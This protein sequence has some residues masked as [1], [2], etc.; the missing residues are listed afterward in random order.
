MHAWLSCRS[1]SLIQIIHQHSYRI[2]I[3][4]IAASHAFPGVV[5]PLFRIDQCLFFGLASMFNLPKVMPILP[6]CFVAPNFVG[7]RLPAAPPMRFF[8]RD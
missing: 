1:I 3:R 4:H 8:K 2:T 5:S 6:F 7:I